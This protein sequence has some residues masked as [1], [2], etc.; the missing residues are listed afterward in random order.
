MDDKIA[1]IDLGSN[2]VH[3]L[4]MK[5]YKNKSYKMIDHVKEM[6][7]LSEGMGEE[8]TLKKEPM[9]RTITTLKL[10]NKL[11]KVYDV[12]NVICLATAA[13]RIAKNRDDFIKKV[14]R[15]TGF[16]IEVISGMEEAYYDFVGVI[17]TIDIKDC[18]IVDIGGASTEII[19]VKDR[20]VKEAISLPF[21]AVL[22]TERFL[23]KD[24][25]NK[26]SLKTLEEHLANQFSNIKWLNDNKRLP[27]VGLGGTIRTIA[28][29]DRKKIQFPFESLHNYQVTPDEVLYVYNRV[30]N[31]NLKQRKNIPGMNKDRADIITGGLAPLISLMKYIE[32]E[33]IIIS[34]NGLREGV[35]FKKYLQTVDSINT[36]DLNRNVIDD[37]LAHSINNIL[38]RYDANIRHSYHVQQLALSLFDQTKELHGL[39]EAERKLLKV[40]ALLHDIGMYVDYYNHHK[41]GFYLMINSRL[42]GLNNRE[43]VICAFIVAM[44]REDKFE[45]NW[46]KYE[47]LINKR[48]YHIIEFLS[49]FARL[50]EKLDRS[51]YSKIKDIYCNIHENSIDIKLKTDEDGELEIV[52]ALKFKKDFKRLLKKNLNII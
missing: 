29:M 24:I 16:K 48:D 33:K 30:S 32:T 23:S 11:I 47:M 34:G 6:V 41:H 39:G 46:R 13:V 42:Y 45:Q 27:I 7:R 35:F 20:M 28:K 4:I 14:K 43:L 2:S 12:K 8:L 22:V 3:V 9:N 17:N 31:L 50:A 25:I 1:I 44:H 5:I 21:G 51:E 26:E 15:E 38:K 37:V 49:L 52:S 10:F 40:G 18:I 36:I 19:L